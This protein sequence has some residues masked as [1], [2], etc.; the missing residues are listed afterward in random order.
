MGLPHMEHARIP[1]SARLYSGLGWVD[2]MMLALGQA[3]A[4]ILSVTGNC[5]QRAVIAPAYSHRFQSRWSLLLTFKIVM[6]K[7]GP[8]PGERQQ[9][10]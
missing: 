4:Q 7:N 5:R 1:N 9:P 2:G 3:G 6:Q 10:S 8:A